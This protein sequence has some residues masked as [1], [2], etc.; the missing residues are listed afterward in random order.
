MPKILHNEAY[1][2]DRRLTFN[3]TREQEARL[4]QLARE[5]NQPFGT[6]LRAMLVDYLAVQKIEWD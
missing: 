2:L 6:L 5:K 1:R 3:T 4:R